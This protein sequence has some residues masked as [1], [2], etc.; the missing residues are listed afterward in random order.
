MN[1]I[2][3]GSGNVASV[4]GRKFY[5]AGHHI[6]QVASRNSKA[7]SALAYEWKT[8]ST[9]YS[10]PIKKNADLYIIAVSD[11]AIAEVTEGLHFPGKIVAH[12]AASVSK[13]VLKNISEH[14]GV[15]YPLQ[16]LRKDSKNTPEIP[17]FIDGS[18]AHT[19]AALEKL[20]HSISTTPVHKA[21]DEDRAKLHLAAVFASNFTNHL[22]ALAQDY[23]EKEGIDFNELRPLIMETMKRL[24]L[25]DPK[26][27]QTGPAARNDEAVIAK[28]LAMLEKYPHL[29]QVYTNLTA[30][31]RQAN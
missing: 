16:S 13:D 31:I 30:S 27:M 11:H 9:N 25:D 8:Y 3:L 19:L 28:H 20:A 14:Y 6:L 18:D 2:L 24:E 4:L 26:N 21:N 17:F 5:K 29:K 15:F 10:G 12:T 7:A 1:I 23:C 22:L